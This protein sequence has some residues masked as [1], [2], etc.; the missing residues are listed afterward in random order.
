MAP[1]LSEPESDEESSVASV[2]GTAPQGK[3]RDVPTSLG[4][5]SLLGCHALETQA[6]AADVLGSLACAADFRVALM[7]DGALQPI[8]QLLH[9]LFQHATNDQ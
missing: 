6:A 1:P 3:E 8:L 7:A 5:Q 4:V 2:G 9:A